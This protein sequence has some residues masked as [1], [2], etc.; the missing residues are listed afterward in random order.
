[1]GA[2]IRVAHTL[3]ARSRA[4]PSRVVGKVA[5]CKQRQEIVIIIIMYDSATS[6]RCCLEHIPK[7][8]EY[9]R[10]ASSCPSPVPLAPRQGVLLHPSPAPVVARLCS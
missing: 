7:S 10:T 3:L 4:S 5:V 1:M 8:R 6:A 2:L 9:D